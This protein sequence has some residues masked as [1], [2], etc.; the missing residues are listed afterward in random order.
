MSII[1]VIVIVVIIAATA[2]TR[3]IIVVVIIVVIV[4]LRLVVILI[5]G[6][7]LRRT[8]AVRQFERLLAF[9]QDLFLLAQ[10]FTPEPK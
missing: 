7:F 2:A 8:D 3:T 5:E 6:A 10:P 9:Q 4:L 1:V